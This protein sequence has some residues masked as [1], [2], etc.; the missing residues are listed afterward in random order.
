MMI[1]N[2][3]GLLL[4]YKVV[5]AETENYFGGRLEAEIKQGEK[6]LGK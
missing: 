4:L 6:V 5:R 3:I 1:P 2:L